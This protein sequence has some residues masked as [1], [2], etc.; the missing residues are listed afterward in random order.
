[1]IGLSVSDSRELLLTVEKCTRWPRISLLCTI[2]E[3]NVNDSRDFCLYLWPAVNVRKTV[4]YCRN[5]SFVR[6]E[7]CSFPFCPCNV[8]IP[9]NLIALRCLA[10]TEQTVK[11]TKKSTNSPTSAALMVS[12]LWFAN[13]ACHNAPYTTITRQRTVYFGNIRRFP[14]H[15]PRPKIQAK[16]STIV[17]IFL[18]YRTQKRNS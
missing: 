14:V 10:L 9:M 3:K 16:I 7:E 8:S 1:M 11:N 15:S 12:L 4:E 2:V 5:I 17:Y 13:L 6:D 18:N